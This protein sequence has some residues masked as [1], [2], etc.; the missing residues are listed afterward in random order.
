MTFLRTLGQ[1]ILLIVTASALL[2]IFNAV[3][4]EYVLVCTGN[5]V[6][7]THVIFRSNFESH[8]E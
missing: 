4:A 1:V 5:K 7:P 6:I 3:R 8:N 2:A